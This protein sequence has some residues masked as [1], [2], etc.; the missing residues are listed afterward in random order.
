MMNMLLLSLDSRLRK[1]DLNNTEDNMSNTVIR[2]VIPTNF[3]GTRTTDRGVFLFEEGN[4]T[5]D[6]KTASS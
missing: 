1:M 2:Y 6:R 5:Y 4:V 3:N